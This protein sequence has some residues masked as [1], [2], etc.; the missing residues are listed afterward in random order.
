[1]QLKEWT[2]M[3]QFQGVL[4]FMNAYG[5]LVKRPLWQEA[6]WVMVPLCCQS[7]ESE[8]LVAFYNM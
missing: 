6:K 2:P 8:L 3:P 7:Q 4:V 1:M 5:D